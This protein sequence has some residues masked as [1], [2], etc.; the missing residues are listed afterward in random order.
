MTALE[1]LSAPRLHDM[2]LPNKTQLEG[3]T[4]RG[5]PVAGWSEA[6]AEGLRVRGHDVEWIKSELAAREWC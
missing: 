4:D 1:A 5:G 3:S 2:V 6:V